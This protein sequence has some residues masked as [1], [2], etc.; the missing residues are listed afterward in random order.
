MP[1]ALWLWCALFLFGCSRACIMGAV[2]VVFVWLFALPLGLWLRRAFFLVPRCRLRYGCRELCLFGCSRWRLRCSCG[3]LCFCLVV[4]LVAFIL[5]A[6]GFVFVRLFALSPAL[7]LRWAAPIASALF[8][9]QRH[10]HAPDFARAVP[11]YQLRP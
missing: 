1:L 3:G 5:V 11:S 7:W 2:G 8:G 9:K 10:Q 6:V 4:R